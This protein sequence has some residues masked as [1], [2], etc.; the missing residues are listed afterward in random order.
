MMRVGIE[1]AMVEKPGGGF[2]K[3]HGIVKHRLQLARV[4]D[5]QR[6]LPE[7]HMS[8]G[9]LTL[10][11]E[12]AQYVMLDVGDLLVVGDKNTLTIRRI[13]WGE[14]ILAI[15]AGGVASVHPA[16]KG[17]HH[18]D[19]AAQTAH[20]LRLHEL[21]IPD[22]AGNMVLG[23]IQLHLAG[24]AVAVVRITRANEGIQSLFNNRNTATFPHNS[25]SESLRD[26]SGVTSLTTAQPRA[27]T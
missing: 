8:Q 1:L 4:V 12:H 27:A 5:V 20:G 11:F 25:K 17:G 3:G 14:D 24:A 18:V 2:V 13:T 7:V 21:R 23:H 9:E 15:K 16:K 19:L 26:F 10:G 6:S 22:E